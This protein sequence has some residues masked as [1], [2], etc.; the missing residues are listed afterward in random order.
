M[1]SKR[2]NLWLNDFRIFN[3]LITFEGR[4]KSHMVG[5][6]VGETYLGSHWSSLPF[7]IWPSPTQERQPSH[8]QNQAMVAFQ[9]GMIDYYVLNGEM[10]E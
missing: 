9:I 1:S 7:G 5:L 10:K 4:C 3:L 2:A 8:S 6:P